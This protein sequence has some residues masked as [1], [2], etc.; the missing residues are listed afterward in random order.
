MTYKPVTNQKRAGSFVL[1][2]DRWCDG[3]CKG[4]TVLLS[5]RAE[6]ASH[7][8]PT[9]MAVIMRMAAASARRCCFVVLAA[10][11]WFIAVIFVVRLAEL[12]LD[13]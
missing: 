6:M 13:A 1:S 5:C 8:T 9:L 7:P 12:D 3:R 10:G 2:T 11:L 4:R